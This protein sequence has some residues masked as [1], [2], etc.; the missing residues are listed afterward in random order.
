MLFGLGF[1]SELQRVSGL[2]GLLELNPDKTCL[3]LRCLEFPLE[4]VELA[5]LTIGKLLYEERIILYAHP[6][7]ALVGN[8]LEKVDLHLCRVHLDF[9]PVHMG[10]ARVQVRFNRPELLELPRG[11]GRARRLPPQLLAQ[12]QHRRLIFN[13]VALRITDALRVRL[14]EVLQLLV[15]GFLLRL[16]TLDLPVDFRGLSSECNKVYVCILQVAGLG[17]LLGPVGAAKRLHFVLKADPFV[18]K[19]LAEA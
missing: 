19:P 10:L 13:P 16:M 5:L 9:I 2:G 6:S 3:V 1:N 7:C 15:Q 17:H 11:L 18:L 8:L 4:S 14:A 12:A